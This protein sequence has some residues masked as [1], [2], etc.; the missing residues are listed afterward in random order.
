MYYCTVYIY[1]DFKYVFPNLLSTF[2]NRTEKK[3]CSQP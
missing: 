2:F 3:R 1:E